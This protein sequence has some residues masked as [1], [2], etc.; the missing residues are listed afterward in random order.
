MPGIKN[1]KANE[2]ATS[3]V[4]DGILFTKEPTIEEHRFDLVGRKT[5]GDRTTEIRVSVKTDE[6]I[7]L[8]SK[9]TKPSWKV[10]DALMRFDAEF[11]RNCEII[12]TNKRKASDEEV[13]YIQGM[14]RKL[15]GTKF[16]SKWLEDEL[17]NLERRR[18]IAKPLG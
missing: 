5:V 10:Q 13:E 6:T 17:K 2:N 4:V 14:L 11:N 1:M 8:K 7:N 18:F 16:G 9:I 3:I 15:L 12:K